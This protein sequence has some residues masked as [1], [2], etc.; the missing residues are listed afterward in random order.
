MD[1]RIITKCLP[2]T[3]KIVITSHGWASYNKLKD[4]GYIHHTVIYEEE[5]VNEEGF[6]TNSI[7]S[8]WSQSKMWINSMHGNR[9]GHFDQYLCK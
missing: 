6:H 5:F 2:T 1:G 8:L 9:T 4:M 7:E 3:A